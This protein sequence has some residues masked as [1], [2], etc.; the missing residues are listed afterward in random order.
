M[1]ICMQ[2]VSINKVTN[3][4][5]WQQKHKGQKLPVL[6]KNVCVEEKRKRRW[7]DS[8]F[9]PQAFISEG[10]RW[11]QRADIWCDSLSISRCSDW[12][13]WS[14]HVSVRRKHALLI[15]ENILRPLT[16]RPKQFSSDVNSFSSLC[17]SEIT[18][19]NIPEKKTIWRGNL[20]DFTLAGYARIHPKTHSE[21]EICAATRNSYE[22][23]E[24][25]CTNI[26]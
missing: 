4:R 10:L 9:F 18:F 26:S 25:I 14:F 19:K 21:P 22:E 12:F 16:K 11:W 17:I 8:L 20:T 6:D 5:Y 13:F 24:N 15:N 23:S 7:K 1:C 3:H 2:T